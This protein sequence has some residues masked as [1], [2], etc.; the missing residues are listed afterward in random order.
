M[1]DIQRELAVRDEREQRAVPPDRSASAAMSAGAG[2]PSRWFV[3][4]LIFVLIGTVCAGGVTPVVGAN[5]SDRLAGDG[6]LPTTMSSDPIVGVAVSTYSVRVP[7]GGSQSYTIKLTK[8][9]TSSVVISLTEGGSAT[10]TVGIDTL[11]DR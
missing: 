3:A 10:I 11:V 4:L 7:E 9:P 8:Q 1:S 5:N 2:A 6:A